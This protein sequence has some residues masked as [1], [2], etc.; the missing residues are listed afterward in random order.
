[1]T[2]TVAGFTVPAGSDPVSSIDD[3]L[4]TMAG[5]IEVA[6]K[7][8]TTNAQTGTSYTLAL[9]DRGKTVSL[10]NASA[11][12]LTVPPQSSVVWPANARIDLTQLGAGQVTVT[13]GSGVTLR[14][15]Q[16][17]TKIAGQYAAAT[18]I[19]I[20]SDEWLLIGALG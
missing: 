1:M 19:R 12:T 17:K 9:T 14:S 7:D 13:P 2:Q 5:E 3:T 8:V 16:S 15:Y 11:I 20:T 6:T 10:A 4:V 18:L